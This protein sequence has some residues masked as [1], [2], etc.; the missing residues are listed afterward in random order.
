[1]GELTV[2]G[3]SGAWP[4][5]GRACSGFLFRDGGTR[6]VLDL[7]YGT[8]S[9]LLEHCP[10]GAV[11]AVVITHEHPDHCADLSALARVR[12][13]RA[14]G[15]PRVPLYCPPGVLDV[16]TAAEPTIDPSAVFDVCPL[17]GRATW[18]IGERIAD[19]I[20]ALA[21]PV[22]H[23][24]PAVGVRLHGPSATVAYTG[25]TGPS[26][27]LT[28][29]GAGAD[30]FVAEATLTDP[31]APPAR[32]L[33]AEQAAGAARAAGASR[34]LLTHFWPGADRADA[35]RRARAVFGGPVLAAHEGLV[36]T[37]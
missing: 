2:L 35:V 29:L 4:E 36:L 18:R 14:A 6:I 20:D 3:S 1:M 23:H 37:V 31:E 21:V 8:V 26:D 11:D 30:L 10:D 33:T 32:L 17:D 15:E 25:D 28:E 34:L 5:A 12:H 27:V 7:G 16:L 22:P 13:Y 19:R 9:R 24:V